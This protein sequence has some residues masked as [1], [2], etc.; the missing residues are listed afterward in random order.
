M[1]VAQKQ[2]KPKLLGSFDSQIDSYLSIIQ[3][4]PGSD[5]D[6]KNSLA[7]IF[8]LIKDHY[9]DISEK[10]MSDVYHTIVGFDLMRNPSLSLDTRHE[11]FSVLFGIFRQGGPYTSSDGASYAFSSDADGLKTLFTAITLI[12]GDKS[13]DV[14]LRESAFYALSKIIS[15]QAA[16]TEYLYHDVFDFCE[17]SAK[18]AD[19]LPIAQSALGV[20]SELFVVM[21]YEL[22]FGVYMDGPHA[23]RAIELV[24]SMHDA[25]PAQSEMCGSYINLLDSLAL[26]SLLY[27]PIV[28]I[29]N[30]YIKRALGLAD[31]LAA[32]PLV[33][34]DANNL[35]AFVANV[36]FYQKQ[37]IAEEDI[38]KALT[39]ENVLLS[40]IQGQGF[41]Y[42]YYNVLFF[43][44][45]IMEVGVESGKVDCQSSGVASEIQTL[46]GWF[47]KSTDKNEKY[48]AMFSV[49]RAVYADPSLDVLHYSTLMQEADQQLASMANNDPDRPLVGGII[50]IIIFKATDYLNMPEYQQMLMLDPVTSQNMVANSPQWADGWFAIPHFDK[51]YD[52]GTSYPNVPVVKNLFDNYNITQVGYYPKEILK[53]QNDHMD[54]LT[55]L[56]PWLISV[57]KHNWNGYSFGYFLKPEYADMFDIYIIEPGDNNHTISLTEQTAARLGMQ[58]NEQSTSGPKFEWFDLSGHGDPWSIEQIV[59]RGGG[60][61]DPAAKTQQMAASRSRTLKMSETERRIY[62]ETRLK[63]VFGVSPKKR[64]GNKTLGNDSEV[65]TD[66][67]P[68]LQNISRFFTPDKTKRVGYL[69]ACSSMG[70]NDGKID[71]GETVA[72]NMGMKVY[73]AQVEFGGFSL[74]FSSDGMRY[75]PSGFDVTV[76]YTV[77]DYANTSNLRGHSIYITPSFSGYQCVL[78]AQ[79]TDQTEGY[80]VQRSLDGGKTFSNIATLKAT[81]PGGWEQFTYDDNNVPQPDVY[82]RFKQRNVQVIDDKGSNYYR[83]AY[84]ATVDNQ[85]RRT[86]VG[87]NVGQSAATEAPFVY[88][89]P[90]SQAATLRLSLHPG[91]TASVH[92]Y[93]TLGMQVSEFKGITENDFHFD[94]G[95]ALAT[96]VYS[97]LIDYESAA[98]SHRYGTSR[99]V[100]TE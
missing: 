60:K 30:P 82:Y 63:Q 79:N 83:F 84:S 90:V 68:M 97:V 48:N 19:S 78:L 27:S 100:K 35:S 49:K 75:E 56:Q 20:I 89:N 7:S 92:V 98:G 96:G 53:K 47:S 94:L 31:D 52:I 54:Q 17:K 77:Y 14:G 61:G 41:A 12:A 8:G 25:N 5:S 85:G 59:V 1:P 18:N 37:N 24:A 44:G 86:G 71:I 91:E 50:S 64:T 99:F 38:N 65:D 33:A 73:G 6:V 2:Q 16:N 4:K 69:E 62:S 57:T 51:I 29:S 93:N 70:N 32:T 36:L 74:E 46:F 81:I 9:N 13:E 23:E 11:T 15:S 21:E 39:I 42:C 55:G 95:R 40:G 26:S 66:D 87:E 67:G 58:P 72:E 3:K 43:I 88:P 45:M 28:S 10:K 80:D 34:N 22:V 76:P